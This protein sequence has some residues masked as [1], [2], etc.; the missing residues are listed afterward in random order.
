MRLCLPARRG[1]GGKA[2]SLPW[3]GPA[4]VA[5]H[6]GATI[7]LWEREGEA[8]GVPNKNGNGAGQA[9]LAA[10]RQKDGT[11]ARRDVNRTPC[12]RACGPAGV[13]PVERQECQRVTPNTP[14]PQERD[15]KKSR[16][17]T[18]APDR[19]PKGPASQKPY[20]A[21]SWVWRVGW[22]YPSKP[23][24]GLGFEGDFQRPPNRPPSSAII[25]KWRQSLTINDCS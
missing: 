7:P 25:G 10:K 4:G 20:R 1:G 19:H 22:R 18:L 17:S 6:T 9:P 24:G 2:E 8:L 11:L 23:F 3:R 21:S 14:R 5:R 13:R 15:F 12:A 16:S